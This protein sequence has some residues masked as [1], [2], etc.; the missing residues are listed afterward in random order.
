VLGYGFYTRFPMSRYPELAAKVD[1]FFQRVEQ[2][3]G[4]DLACHTGCS[5]CC[6]TRL[7]ITRV[8][9]E[10]LAAEIEAW[11]AQQRAALAANAAASTE[12]CSALANGRCLIYAARPIVCRSHGAPIRLRE[13]SL[14]VVKACFRNFPAG[15]EKADADCILDQQTLSALV[16]AVNDGDDG[17]V[18]LAEL[19]ESAADV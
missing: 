18:D 19:L 7:T 9:A 2:R 14:P 12:D 5:D 6:Q 3:H 4:S 8:E 16:L 15:P 10:A 1:A 13:G 11:P 17:R